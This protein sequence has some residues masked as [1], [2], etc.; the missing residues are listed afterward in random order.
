MTIASRRCGYEPCAVWLRMMENMRES[1]FERCSE[2]MRMTM[3]VFDHS[4]RAT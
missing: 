3:T 1:P 2:H 4:A